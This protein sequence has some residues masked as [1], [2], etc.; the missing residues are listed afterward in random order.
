MHIFA[1]ELASGHILM[2]Y[3]H[4]TPSL[5]FLL[6]LLFL[7]SFSSS[8]QSYISK[9]NGNWTSGNTWNTVANG[10]SQ[11]HSGAVPPVNKDWG[12]TVDIKIQHQVTYPGNLTNF[13]N[14]LVNGLEIASGGSLTVAGDF[15]LPAHG[16]GS[17]TYLKMGE[18][19]SLNVAGTWSVGKADEIVIPKNAIVTV[20]NLIVD[21]NSLGIVLQEGAELIVLNT[22]TI[23]AEST[24]HIKGKYSTKTLTNNSGNL[25]SSRSGT[26]QIEGNLSLNGS[27]SVV[28]SDDSKIV[29][30]GR[31]TTS[32]AGLMN[33]SGSSQISLA[34]D[35]TLSEGSR[36]T[37][38]ENS[39]M[40]VGGI[41]STTGAAFIT[42]KGEATGTVEKDITLKEGAILTVS[43]K[44]F[45][46]AHGNI[47]LFEGT[48]FNL[49]GNAE[50][51]IGG[52]IDMR[53]GE[54]ITSGNSTLHIDKTLRAHRDNQVYA[55][56]QSGIYICDYVNSTQKE[57]KFIRAQPLSYYGPGCQKLPVHWLELKVTLTADKKNKVAWATAKEWDNSHF[58]IERSING[59]HVFSKISE[60]KGQGWSSDI[61]HYSFVDENLPRSSGDVYY[62]VKQVD[63]DNEYDY[64]IVLKAVTNTQI[65]PGSDKKWRA[66]P[67]PTI[68]N[69]LKVSMANPDRSIVGEVTIRMI[70]SSFQS[71]TVTAR[72]GEELDRVVLQLFEKAPKGI[73]IIE[74]MWAEETSHLKILKIN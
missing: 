61:S 36:Y 59:G 7:V 24:L 42:F 69:S 37:F 22:T 64:S 1:S 47:S 2:K 74:L 29:S 50:G 19:A 71:E 38:H 52:N 56:D 18:G 16:W 17:L 4:D 27:A 39:S 15:A 49:N 67:N 48:K 32:G 40:K 72:Y 44:S 41:L 58:E 9:G 8:G 13:G 45:L 30:G 14:G 66:Y 55:H 10:C 31:L 46:S 3:S 57:S 26:T 53:N 63:F 54:I 51:R 28:F 6:V 43:D 23:K 70:S 68:G 5:T 11:N 34:G 35:M 20:A 25:I 60:V 73:I 62:R 33:F 65:N 21:D 12:C